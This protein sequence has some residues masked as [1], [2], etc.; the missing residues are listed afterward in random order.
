MLTHSSQEKRKPKRVLVFGTKGFIGTE[1]VQY[2]ELENINYIPVSSQD[3]DLTATGSALELKNLIEDG[4][5]LVFLSAITPDKGRELSDY[6]KNIKMG[7]NLCKGIENKSIEHMIYLSSDAVYPFESGE[8][9]E[10]S[11]AAPDDLYGIMH[12]SREIFFNTNK[13]IKNLAVLRPTLIYGKHDTHN[14]YGANRFSRMVEQGQDITLFGK[15]EELRD[16]VYIKDLINLI[17]LVVLHKSAGVLNIATGNSISFYDLAS[18][19]VKLQNSK[20]KII[21]TERLNDITNRKFDVSILK[22]SFPEFKYTSLEE[23][24]LLSQ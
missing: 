8:T 18:K 3:V 13:N 24:L 22:R 1:L 14:S 15:G 17:G 7:L 11:Y 20:I 23:G 4:D 16:H 21:E 19:I 5:S 9:N 10:Q 2:L 12:R 6:N